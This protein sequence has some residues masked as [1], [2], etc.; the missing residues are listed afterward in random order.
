MSCQAPISSPRVYL[1]LSN[2]NVAKSGQS[3][4]VRANV[5]GTDELYIFVCY[6]MSVVI[7]QCTVVFET[8]RTLHDQ[9][10]SFP[11]FP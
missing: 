7:G 3:K 6:T 4:S 11:S 9:A 2:L 1:L 5:K 8:R 10:D